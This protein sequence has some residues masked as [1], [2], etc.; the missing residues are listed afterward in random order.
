MKIIEENNEYEKSVLIDML[1]SSSS[2]AQAL[3]RK[4]AR[5]GI[6]FNIRGRGD[7]AVYTIKRVKNPFKIFAIINLGFSANTD[8]DKLKTFYWCYFNDDKLSKYPVNCQVWALEKSGFRIT[9]QTAAHYINKLIEHDWIFKQEHSMA[10]DYYFSDGY[11]KR[12]RS[13][14]K[15]EYSKAW[16]EFYENLQNGFTI[17]E[18]FSIMYS[19]YGGIAKKHTPALMALELREPLPYMLNLIEDSIS[20]DIKRSYPI[21]LKR[22]YNTVN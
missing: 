20:E 2:S 18:A 14:A 1:G 22:Y 13:A 9:R 4:L 16:S 17:R 12:F 15:E 10:C 6:D 19:D 7:N 5:L 8:F 21:N 3:N 11:N